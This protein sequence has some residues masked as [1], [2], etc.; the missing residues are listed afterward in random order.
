MK[1]STESSSDSRVH[2]E[3]VFMPRVI[4]RSVDWVEV[5]ERQVSDYQTATLR[6][7]A[8][9]L[10]GGDSFNPWIIVNSNLSAAR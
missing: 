2:E 4:S 10:V 6:I 8:A 7:V 1:Y 9:R 5:N 3:D